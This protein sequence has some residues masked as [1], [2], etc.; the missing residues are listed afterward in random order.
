MQFLSELKPQRILEFV[1]PGTLKSSIFEDADEIEL[2][3][4]LS[5]I[6]DVFR[7]IQSGGGSTFDDSAYCAHT[8]AT[9]LQET[10]KLKNNSPG[11]ALFIDICPPT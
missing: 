9:T 4:D 1:I 11:Q 3:G 10:H 5:V 8:I 6:M 2:F 7:Y